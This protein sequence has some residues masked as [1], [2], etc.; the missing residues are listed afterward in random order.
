NMES[1]FDRQ[2]GDEGVGADAVELPERDGESGNGRRPRRRRR[3]G[4][5]DERGD[6]RPAHRSER[7][8]F[9]NNGEADDAGSEDAAHADQPEPR[10]DLAE[11]APYN[12]AGL[13]EQ[14]SLAHDEEGRE[15]RP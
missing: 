11:E 3:R 7:A 9:A 1:G 15:E 12:P 5:R 10:E 4:R 2:E 6:D 8:E 13:G 14:P